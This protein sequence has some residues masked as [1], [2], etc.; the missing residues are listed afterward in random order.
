MAYVLSFTNFAFIFTQK[1]N[2]REFLHAH[3]FIA[4]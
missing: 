2:E 1:K 4:V 3:L